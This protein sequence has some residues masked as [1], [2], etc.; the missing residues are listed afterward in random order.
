MPLAVFN[1]HIFIYIHYIIIGLQKYWQT[2]DECTPV[3][4]GLSFRT[5]KHI[6]QN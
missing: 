5:V 2:A 3:Q 4:L 1:V 6:E